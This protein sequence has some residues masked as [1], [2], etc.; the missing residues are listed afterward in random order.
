[1]SFQIKIINVK[2]CCGKTVIFNLILRE[3]ISIK[4]Y[5]GSPAS[6]LKVLKPFLSNHKKKYVYLT[7]NEVVALFYTV[8]TDW[9][10]YG[11]DKETGLP[12]FT[13]YY[14]DELKDLYNNKVGYIYEVDSESIS[15]NPTN[16]SCAVVVEHDIQIYSETKINNLYDRFLQYEK[17]QRLIIKRYGE[18]SQEEIK[19]INKIVVGEI[20]DNLYNIT[21]GY[22]KFLKEKFPDIWNEC[23]SENK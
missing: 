15:K 5:H 6:G 19:R 1:M 22:S 3:M 8:K 10:T 14:K 4:Y 13:E 21:S 20:K 12:V 18:L 17:E 16:I 11:F 2:F 9:Y 7:T 23:L